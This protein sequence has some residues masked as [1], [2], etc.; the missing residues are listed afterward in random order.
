MVSAEIIE[1]DAEAMPARSFGGDVVVTAAQVLH[2]G[3]SRSE[4]S[5]R[6]VAL[7]AAHRPQPCLQPPVVRLDGSVR[8][9]LNSVQ[10]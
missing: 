7:Q 4:D 10:G 9:P 6:A 1:G 5:G 2:E 8:M 3:M